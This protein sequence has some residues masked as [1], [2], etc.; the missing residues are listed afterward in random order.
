MHKV[1]PW[2]SISV[3]AVAVCVAAALHIAWQNH[4]SAPPAPTAATVSVPL[5]PRTPMQT[6]DLAMTYRSHHIEV[7]TAPCPDGGPPDT[8][9]FFDGQPNPE[10]LWGLPQNRETADRWKGAVVVRF[11]PDRRLDEA[12]LAAWGDC[13]MRAGPY[14]FFGDPVWIARSHE[15]FDSPSPARD[16]G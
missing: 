5:P 10:R 9:L 6:S 4:P 16:G 12:V 15:V 8:Y 11:H 7:Q 1:L 14:L 3:V 13:G 2:L